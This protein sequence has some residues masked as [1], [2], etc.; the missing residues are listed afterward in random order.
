MTPNDDGCYATFDCLQILNENDKEYSNKCPFGDGSTQCCFDSQGNFTGQVCPDGT[1]SYYNGSGFDCIKGWTPSQLPS[2]GYGTK[3]IVVTGK[4]T[5][6][7]S[8]TYSRKCVSGDD[9]KTE[10]CRDSCAPGYGGPNCDAILQMNQLFKT[11]PV[12]GSIVNDLGNLY[13]ILL[14]GPGGEIVI[15]LE[16]DVH[17]GRAYEDENSNI[18]STIQKCADS[19]SCAFVKSIWKNM[20]GSRGYVFGTSGVLDQ[21]IHVTFKVKNTLT[22]KTSDQQRIYY[23]AGDCSSS[24][25]NWNFDGSSED[26]KTH[27]PNIQT[28][29]T[30]IVTKTTS[31][32]PFESCLTA[33]VIIAGIS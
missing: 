23:N 5:N 22:N 19:G 12:P 30:Q 21:T 3:C 4:E 18:D 24:L 14:P 9:P 33:P 27:G 11:N 31:Y 25:D 28:F 17:W 32:G 15:D 6:P 8:K 7:P 1:F 2:P 26:R 20:Y 29:N 13:L 16:S 10:C